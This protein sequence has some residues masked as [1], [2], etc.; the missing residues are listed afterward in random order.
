MRYARAVF[1]IYDIPV[2]GR[3]FKKENSSGRGS[4]R[5]FGSRENE[6]IENE[7]KSRLVYFA[8]KQRK[9][10]RIHLDV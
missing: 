8:G 10:A 3:F 1:Y 2:R 7:I 9:M 6:R 4:C 5:P